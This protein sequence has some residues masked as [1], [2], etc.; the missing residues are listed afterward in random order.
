MT[1][2]LDKDLQDRIFCTCYGIYYFGST[3]YLISVVLWY[4]IP[5]IEKKIWYKICLW[6]IT[7]F[8]ID[9]LG[10]LSF[11]LNDWLVDSEDN[12]T[13]ELA[14]LSMYHGI[15]IV[16]YSICMIIFFLFSLTLFLIEIAKLC[17]NQLSKLEA[18]KNN[19]QSFKIPI[20]ILLINFWSIISYI[21]IYPGNSI[22]FGIFVADNWGE[23][24]F[25]YRAFLTNSL[26]I[27]KQYDDLF[28]VI[29]PIVQFL[30]TV[31][32]F[33]EFRESFF[34]I[35]TCGKLYNYD[36]TEDSNRWAKEVKNKN[37][38]LTNKN[39]T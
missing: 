17:N 8:S 3:F 6:P 9:I 20:D 33:K 16:V 13:Y 19:F 39:N 23:H 27:T 28:M 18:D 36:L 4:Y 31:I 7:I 12:Y 2:N 29:A 15:S 1:S 22:I 26:K 30:L 32:F 10:I 35:I 5:N 11:F 14:P 25:K 37:L 24:F 34:W 21:I 38:F